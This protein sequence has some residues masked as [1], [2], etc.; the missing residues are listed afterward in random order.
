[1]QRIVL[2][3][4][5]AVVVAAAASAQS[6]APAAT[7]PSAEILKKTFVAQVEGI[8]EKFDGVVSYAIVDLTSGERFTRHDQNVQP[9]A[10]TIKLGVLYELMKQ[11]EA[12]K[13]SL[14]AQ[15]PLDRKKVVGGAGILQDLGT[16]TLSIRDYAQLMAVIS[17]NTATNV[18][19]DAVTM[20]AV[21]V[22]MRTL[23]LTNTK[24]RRR[25]MDSAAARRGDENVTTAGDLAK[26]ME[27]FFKG[28]G[29]TPA[30][31]D[32]ALRILKVRNDLKRTPMLNAI[33]AQVEVANKEGDLEGVWADVGIVFVKNRPYIFS[34]MTTYLQD[35]KAGERVIEDLS[36]AAY[37]YFSRLG[38]GTE[39]GRQI[40]R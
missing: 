9:S 39:Y 29:L 24:L 5:A 37:N 30:G 26:L 2:L 3:L 4:T 12:G 16:P 23:G 34:V 15:V 19:I 40:G 11:V 6:P 32:E 22:R 13:L 31:R 21:N 7:N 25:M 28:Q 33:P 1:M 14:D 18:V 36:R 35:D 38:A 27:I 8:A 17:D 20:D 10:S